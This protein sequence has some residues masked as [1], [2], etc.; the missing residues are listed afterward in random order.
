[1]NEVVPL[2]RIVHTENM[3]VGDG[4]PVGELLATIVLS[5]KDDQ[6]LLRMTLR[7]P[8]KE[9]RDGALASLMERGVAAG[10]LALVAPMR[11]ACQV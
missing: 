7:F 1:M 3:E 2:E 8:S 10:T 4:I 11:R 6:T 9:D 5:E